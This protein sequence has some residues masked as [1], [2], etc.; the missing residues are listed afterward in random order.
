MF[1]ETGDLSELRMRYLN[2]SQEWNCSGELYDFLTSLPN[3]T[4]DLG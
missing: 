2:D 3:N 4:L 1:C